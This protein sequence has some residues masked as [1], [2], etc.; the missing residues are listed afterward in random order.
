MPLGGDVWAI[1][2]GICFVLAGIA[3]LSG[4]LDVLA[5][6]LLALMLLVFSALVLAPPVFASPRDH[7]AWGSNAYNL[8]AVGAA[9]ILADW[10]A[11]RHAER[12]PDAKV[13]LVGFMRHFWRG[14]SILS[15]TD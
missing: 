1:A 15:R 10:I 4:I 13:R 2:T 6:R 11:S 9:W 7:V 5:T 14:G 12:E 3:I 8:A